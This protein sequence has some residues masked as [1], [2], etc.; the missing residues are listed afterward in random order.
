MKAFI[1]TE[2]LKKALKRLDVTDD[3]I[4]QQIVNNLGV[5]G[6]NVESQAKVNTPVNLGRLRS[7]IQQNLDA[8]NMQVNIK[9]GGTSP[10][11][12]LFYAPFV[13]FGTKGK[14]RVPAGY[15]QF[16]YQYKGSRTGT[17]IE[18]LS[19]ITQ[20]VADKGIDPDA[21]FPIAMS[22]A[23]NGIRAQPYLIPAFERE[24]PQL[25]RRLKK[26]KP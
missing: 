13:E 26:I 24:A 8:K 14:V 3:R 21:A 12:D 4:R 6:L 19:S 5:A 18:L 2:D 16:A 25:V 15:A 23:K 22:I 17:F 1:K 7:S 11:G 20:W 10:R 9:A